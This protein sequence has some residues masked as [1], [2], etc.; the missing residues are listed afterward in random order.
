MATSL[1]WR[2]PPPKIG[3]PLI[4]VTDTIPH[5]VWTTK[6]HFVILELMS[7]RTLLM[8]THFRDVIKVPESEYSKPGFDFKDHLKDRYDYKLDPGI[9]QRKTTPPDKDLLG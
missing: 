7:D 4:H 8:F 6:Y 2:H 5:I 9:Y 1:N 3:K